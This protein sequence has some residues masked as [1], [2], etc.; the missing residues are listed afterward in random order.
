VHKQGDRL[1]THTARAGASRG[2]RS[3]RRRTTNID[4]GRRNVAEVIRGLAAGQCDDG[5]IL[6]RI[7]SPAD[8]KA[9]SLEECDV[10]AGEI[11]QFLVEAVSRTGGHLGSNLGAVELTIALP[12]VFDS[13]SDM[14][15]FDT[16]HQAY[17][18]KLL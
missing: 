15:V 8:V 18:H 1:V 14:L 9:L 17:V 10:L 16:G 11:R 7:A 13:P 4:G 5:T 6:D 2:S 3:V 12:R